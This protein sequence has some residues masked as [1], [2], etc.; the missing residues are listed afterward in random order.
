MIAICFMIGSFVNFIPYVIPTPP[1]CE[2][3]VDLIRDK[4]LLLNGISRNK[5]FIVH[6][7]VRYTAVTNAGFYSI[8]LILLTMDAIDILCLVY[9]NIIFCV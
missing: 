3:F 5:Q 4:H 6:T 1:E 8:V 7:I 2:I 9:S